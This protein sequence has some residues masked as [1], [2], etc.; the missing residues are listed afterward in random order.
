MSDLLGDTSVALYTTL[1]GGTALTALLAGTTSV[2]ESQAPD[3]STYPFVVFNHQGGGPDNINPS[4]IESNLWLVKVYSATSAKSASDI[5]AQA[6]ALLHRKNISIGSA[7]TFWCC[8]EQNV[9][10]VENP[11]NGVIRYMRGGIY[12]IR[13]TG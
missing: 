10:L 9:K 7:K 4:E 13:T 8:R 2:Y 12:R 1:A 11:P 5:F 3:K 6:D